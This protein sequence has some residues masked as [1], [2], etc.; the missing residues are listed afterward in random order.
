MQRNTGRRFS[1]SVVKALDWEA[2]EER[3]NAQ[4]ELLEETVKA[5][6]RLKPACRLLKSVAG[7]GT[8]LALTIML[9]TGDI[10]RFAKS[11]QYA[12]YCRKASAAPTT[13]RKAK[14]AFKDY[15]LGI[16]ATI[17]KGPPLPPFIFMGSA[18]M[19]APLLGNLSRFVTF[20]KPG[21]LCLN[22]S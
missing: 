7:I 18:T 5:Q 21:T 14:A 4:I 10:R 20:S 17:R 2:V 16:K 8:V 13:R 11:G 15:L 19:I 22:K 3:L 1:G 12:S 9:E 6:V